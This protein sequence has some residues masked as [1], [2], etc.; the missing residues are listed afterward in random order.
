MTAGTFG[1][2]SRGGYTLAELVASMLAMSF[3]TA[4]LVS[5]VLIATQANDVGTGTSK[6]R[7]DGGTAV[8]EL[9]AE[10]QWATGILERSS[11]AVEFQ[12]VR[13]GVLQ[14]V[15]YSWSGTPGDPLLR[16]YDEG[17]AATVVSDVRAFDLAYLTDS[18][19]EVEVEP[20]GTA[21]QLLFAYET[22]SSQSDE[23]V[24]FDK[25]IGS[26][27]SPVLPAD[28]TSWRVTRAEVRV[29][30]ETSGQRIYLQL[31]PATENTPGALLEETSLDATTLST[32]TSW[33]PFSFSG[34]TALAPSQSVCLVLAATSG[35]FPVKAR[36]ASGGVSN[37]RV[38]LV[39]S[40]NQGG[41]WTSESDKALLI[42]VYGTVDSANS[43]A[44]L[45]HYLTHVGIRIQVGADSK[46]LVRA[47]CPLFNLP[48]VPAP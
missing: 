12:V 10:L 2:V 41:A 14:S 9:I 7:I 4:G 42:R 11:T 43:S 5:S 39:R 34:D 8:D 6:A 46:A 26:R 16:S 47:G 44:T 31:R 20:A 3:L 35:Q 13:D 21:E 40:S 37:T 17:P 27:V 38:N 48:E 33:V 18:A 30:R 32:T 29:K 45:V 22:S 15:R 36:Y 19:S 24:K 28:A 25:W 23:D 1:Q